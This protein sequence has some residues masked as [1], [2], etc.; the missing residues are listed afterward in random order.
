MHID[1]LPPQRGDQSV[2]EQI[3]AQMARYA[4]PVRVVEW[5]RRTFQSQWY[6][7]ELELLRQALALEGQKPAKEGKAKSADSAQPQSK[8]KTEEPKSPDATGAETTITPTAEHGSSDESISVSES[9]QVNQTASEQGVQS[10]EPSMPPNAN[11]N[12]TQQPSQN[13]RQGQ[14]NK[15]TKRNVAPSASDEVAASIREPKHDRPGDDED[16]GRDVDEKV[17]KP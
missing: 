6:G 10:A 13:D 5:E 2:A 7:R 16:S 4:R 15:K 9:P 14:D 8:R 12:S 17:V 1:T 3:V 11:L